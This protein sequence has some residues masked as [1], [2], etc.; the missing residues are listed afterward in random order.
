MST[1][2]DHGNSAHIL[3]FPYPALGHI[4]PLLDLT[5]LFLTRGLTVTVLVTPIHLPLLDPLL[6]C[7]PSTSIQPLVLTPPDVQASTT[8]RPV[9]NARALS[10]LYNPIVQW[11]RSHPSPPV[12]IVSDI[13]L[14][15]THNLGSDLGVP[16][17][18]FWPSGSFA[19]SICNCLWRDL[20]MVDDPNDENSVLSFP[21]VPNCPKYPQWQISHLYRYYQAG[22][23]DWELFRSS[24][25]ANSESWGAVFNSFTELERVYM[26]H[27]KKY[28][29]HDRVWAVGPLLPAD[30]DVMGPTKRGGSSSVPTQEVISWLDSKGNNSVVYVCFGS[31]WTVTSQQVVALLDALDRSE[32]GVAVRFCEVGTRTIPDPTEL[33]RKLVESVGGCK[34]Q[35]DRVME[36]RSAASEAILGGSSSRDMDEDGLPQVAISKH[37]AVGVFVPDCEW[38]S[39]LDELAVGMGMLMRHQGVGQFINSNLLVEQP[40]RF[41]EVGTRKIPNSAESV[42]GCKSQR[43]RVMELP[44][45]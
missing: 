36:L 11:F 41:C 6:S 32:L 42:G 33:A 30:D 5:H 25:T 23:P 45:A 39:V 26:D 12:A 40:V 22:D 10:E 19:A 38:N 44:A 18:V 8:C 34:S 17:I 24:M 29:G 4:I 28:M 2:S 3:V 43:D 31:G 16:R 21:K 15:W 27:V 7:H 9:A 14:G 13:F 35:R 20:P 1:N 37:R